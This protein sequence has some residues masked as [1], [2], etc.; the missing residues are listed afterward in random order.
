MQDTLIITLSQ[1]DYM[2]L[3]KLAERLGETSIE[4]ATN[5]IKA[6]IS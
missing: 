2:K 3:T 4:V 5:I 6:A 1:E